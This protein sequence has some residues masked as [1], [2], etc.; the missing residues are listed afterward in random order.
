MT[1]FNE[2]ILTITEAATA[3][4]ID[5]SVLRWH[6]RRGSI[7]S[8]RFSDTYVILQSALNEFIAARA[9]GRFVK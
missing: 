5:P 7:R 2:P 6:V 3:V 8:E 9:E 4:G 1:Y